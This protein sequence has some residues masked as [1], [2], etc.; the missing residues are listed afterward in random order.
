MFML[1]YFHNY[2]CVIKNVNIIIIIII[3]PSQDI[4]IAVN[5]YVCA[6]HWETAGVL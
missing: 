5:N 1:Q 6:W 4:V 3:I 2:N